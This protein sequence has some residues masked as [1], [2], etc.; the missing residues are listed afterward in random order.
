MMMSYKTSISV[1]LPLRM[2]ILR[3]SGDIECVR[4]IVDQNT[5]N[6]GIGD[7]FFN[8]SSLCDYVEDNATNART[9][10]DQN[11]LYHNVSSFFSME[12]DRQSSLIDLSDINIDDFVDVTR[13]KKYAH[14]DMIGIVTEE[15]LLPDIS[16]PSRV[17]DTSGNST[18]I[19]LQSHNLNEGELLLQKSNITVEDS[20]QKSIT[21]TESSGA[22]ISITSAD[23]S[24]N[25]II[26]DINNA[27]TYTPIPN[28]EINIDYDKN[29][30]LCKQIKNEI[31]DVIHFSSERNIM[32][33]LSYIDCS[34]DVKYF[35]TVNVDKNLPKTAALLIA[36]HFFSS[37][38]AVNNQNNAYGELYAAGGIGKIMMSLLSA[39]TLFL[40]IALQCII[41]YYNKDI[42]DNKD[43]CIVFTDGSSILYEVLKLSKDY[44]KRISADIKCSILCNSFLSLISGY[45]QEIINKNNKIILFMDKLFISNIS[46][47]IIRSLLLNYI[48]NPEKSH[49]KIRSAILESLI[50]LA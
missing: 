8:I 21:V 49:A 2:N 18:N 30:I 38:R 9:Q 15:Q 14:C 39:Q 16:T 43:T 42:S 29:N 27:Y 23:G 4:N 34:S 26:Q 45:D 48:N 24:Q 44:L 35:H 25:F 11:R 37:I 40:I 19:I 33:L 46:D 12:G 47:S 13:D 6:H 28:K 5:T 17:V 1:T 31:Y 7:G 41:Y 50:R 10:D 3:N 22:D 36:H 32:Y 20:S